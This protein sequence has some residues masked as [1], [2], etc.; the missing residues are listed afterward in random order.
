MSKVRTMSA[1]GTPPQEYGIRNKDSRESR[2]LRT[3]RD[4]IES[5]RPLTY[6][7]S[8]EEQRLAH[9]LREAAH[10]F[11]PSPV[12]V[13]TWSLTEG[14]RRSDGATAGPSAGADTA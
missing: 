10:R 1:V 6:I 9:L 3:L 14:M 8:A 11:F 12:P 5:G 2:S 4:I 7:Q 13:W